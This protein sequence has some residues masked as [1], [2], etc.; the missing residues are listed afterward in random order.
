MIVVKAYTPRLLKDP[1]NNLESIDYMWRLL[2]GLGCVPACFALYFRLTIPETP[3]FTMDIE[4]NVAQASQDVETVLAKGTYYVDPDAQVQRVEAPKASRSDFFSYYGKW[5]NLKVLIGTSWSWFALDVA[6][7]GLG[8]NTSLILSA[9]GWAGKSGTQA[10]IADNLWKICVGNL[11]LIV[12]GLIPGYWATFLFID[13]IGRKPIQYM[14]FSVLFVLFCIMVSQTCV[15]SMKECAHASSGLRLPQARRD[16]DRPERVRRAL[17]S[18]Q[19]LPEL[20]PEHDD[21]HRPRRGL[22]NALPL[23]LARHLGRVRQARRDRRAG[24]L[25]APRQHWR[26]E[27]LGQ[28]HHDHLRVHHAHGRRVDIPNPGDKPA[29]A[30]GPL[31]RGPVWLCA[32]SG[33]QGRRVTMSCSDHIVDSLV[34]SWCVISYLLSLLP[35]LLSCGVG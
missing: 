1:L 19:L 9:I 6:F 34:G 2:I 20:R 7:Y 32:R 26:Y 3:R 12:A 8:L 24:R 35:P 4:R 29:H 15:R 28:Q 14:G 18:H 13:R 27:R 25:R 11:I 17:L 16:P 5:E 33:Q 21:V 23:D 31:E 30:R 22:P 10:L